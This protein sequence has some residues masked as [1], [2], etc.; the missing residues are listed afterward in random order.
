M[1]NMEVKILN[2]VSKYIKTHSIKNK[3]KEGNQ[4]VQNE[5]DILNQIIQKSNQEINQKVAQH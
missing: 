5:E 3:E 1:K 2:I 4:N